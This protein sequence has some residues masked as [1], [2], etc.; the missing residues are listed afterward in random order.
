VSTA[1]EKSA[2]TTTCTDTAV[3]PTSYTIRSRESFQR[4]SWL[5]PFSTFTALVVPI[6]AVA[7]ATDSF[8]SRSEIYANLQ[9]FYYYETYKYDDNYLVV[10]A[11]A[12]F[13]TVIAVL[14]LC[15][16]YRRFS[17]RSQTRDIDLSLIVCPL[18]V[19]RSKRTTTTTTTK[20]YNSHDQKINLQKNV[21]VHHY[22]LLPIESVKDCILLEHVGGFSVTTHVM[23]RLNNKSLNNI[24]STTVEQK[25][26]SEVQKNK[27][28]DAASGLVA[29]FPDANLTFDQCHGL[30][31]QIRSALAEVQ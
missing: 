2:M 4:S 18:G 10:A 11:V 16:A 3:A 24:E 9:D 19:Q 17:T 13:S 28:K 20:T 31:N 14:L 7:T 27:K 29:A 21:H 6:V 1:C 30:V 8:W 26:A 15:I 23:I 25:V 5:W 22:P 12:A